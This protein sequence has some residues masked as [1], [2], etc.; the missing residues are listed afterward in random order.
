MFSIEASRLPHFV[1]HVSSSVNSSKTFLDEP[2]GKPI[3]ALRATCFLVGK[4]LEN[5]PH[6]EVFRGCTIIGIFFDSCIA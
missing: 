4:L 1:L 6:E 5:I 2:S 3:T